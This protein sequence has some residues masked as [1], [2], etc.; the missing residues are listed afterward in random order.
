MDSPNLSAIDKASFMEG[1]LLNYVNPLHSTALD[2]DLNT[3]EE[4]RSDRGILGRRDITTAPT[5]QCGAAVKT[6][7]TQ[8]HGKESKRRSTSTRAKVKTG[9][10]VKRQHL[11]DHKRET[12]PDSRKSIDGV[13]QECD[14]IT[15]VFC[16][17][18]RRMK[19]Q[20]SPSGDATKAN[21]DRCARK[22]HCSQEGTNLEVMLDAFLDYCDLYRR[23]VDSTVVK[24]SIEYFSNKVKDQLLEKIS[25]IEEVDVL[26]KD[27]TTVGSL[28]C[29]KT[30]TLLD[31]KYEL[32]RAE[33]KEA[34]L[35]KE[36]VELEH[37]LSCLRRGQAFLFD[38]RELT[39][40]Y[41]DHQESHNSA[42]DVD[43]RDNRA[44]DLN[45]ISLK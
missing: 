11:K 6:K 4:R 39:R 12:E 26:N 10:L 38:I 24:E 36:R 33:R 19:R 5:A 17:V 27:N 41:L 28:V 31:T 43:F 20:G 44:D 32:M 35:H 30:Q 18:M 14:G 37:R 34:F 2:E 23:S 29:T 25:T 45:I 1:L 16:H 40:V 9:T 8:Y 22:G 21:L 7:E 13:L 42:V 3:L 15:E